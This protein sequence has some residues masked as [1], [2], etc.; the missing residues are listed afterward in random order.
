MVTKLVGLV[1]TEIASVT[2]CD[3][4]VV[5]AIYCSLWWKEKGPVPFEIRPSSTA[6]EDFLSASRCL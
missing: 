2:P 1:P 4:M 5:A 3:S 6:L